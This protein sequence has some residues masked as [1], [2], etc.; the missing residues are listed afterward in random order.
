M[1]TSRDEIRL[2]WDAEETFKRLYAIRAQHAGLIPFE[3]HI[4][5][6]P[7]WTPAPDPV[8]MKRVDAW[9]PKRTGADIERLR[10]HVKNCKGRTD[11]DA[12]EA[13]YGGG[14]KPN[15]H[16]ADT[17]VPTA[18]PA[19]SDDLYEPMGTMPV[20]GD[21]AVN[22]ETGTR[23]RVIDKRSANGHLGIIM[24]ENGGEK[25]VGYGCFKGQP[26]LYQYRILKRQPRKVEGRVWKMNGTQSQGSTVSHWANI[27]GVSYWR[28]YN[29][30]WNKYALES[31]SRL[32]LASCLDELHGPDADAIIREC[33]SAMGV[34]HG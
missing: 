18:A 15:P 5:H 6:R 23:R 24:D 19:F 22:I 2:K 25:V 4:A 7:G 34:Q 12:L 13:K 9:P 21:I 16:G 10:E 31:G 28:E 29:G 20:V 33:V 11:N 26:E 3:M 1:K 8:A 32:T 14:G 17:R 27:G 30:S